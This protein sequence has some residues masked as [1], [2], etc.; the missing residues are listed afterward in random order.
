ME[1][2]TLTHPT[3]GK[4]RTA[5]IDGENCVS[6]KDVLNISGIGIYTVYANSMIQAGQI[7]LLVASTD[8]DGIY[9]TMQ[10]VHDFL[11]RTKLNAKDQYRFIRWIEAELSPFNASESPN[12]FDVMYKRL[13]AIADDF[14]KSLESLKQQKVKTYST[15]E[16]AKELGITA[17]KLNRELCEQGLQFHDE[18]GYSLTAPYAHTGLACVEKLNIPTSKGTKNVRQLKWTEEGKNYILSILKPEYNG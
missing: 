14:R 5:L 16:V 6:L 10:G 13:A 12:T 11:Q 3:F 9:L 4:I 1:I 8:N 18:D 7:K 2:K 15:T 17:I